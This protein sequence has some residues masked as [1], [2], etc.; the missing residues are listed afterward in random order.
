MLGVICLAFDDLLVSFAWA[1]VCGCLFGVAGALWFAAMRVLVS[2]WFCGCSLEFW[3]VCYAVAVAI[4]F[5]CFG[6]VFSF[7]FLCSG[8]GVCVAFVWFCF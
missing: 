3:F 7:E 5:T 8:C 6:F 1:L 4:P 2:V